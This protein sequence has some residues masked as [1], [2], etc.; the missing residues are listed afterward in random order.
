MQ[1]HSI[2]LDNAAIQNPLA[3]V[4]IRPALERMFQSLGQG[5]TTQSQ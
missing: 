1:Q 4:D 5:T 2:V 3:K